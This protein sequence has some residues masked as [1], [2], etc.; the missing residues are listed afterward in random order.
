MTHWLGNKLPEILENR[1]I[2]TRCRCKL[3]PVAGAYACSSCGQSFGVEGGIPVFWDHAD[4][5]KKSEAEFYGQEAKNP[6]LASLIRNYYHS[7]RYDD[8]LTELQFKFLKPN[9]LI[10]SLG[11]G[12][13]SNSVIYVKRGFKVLESDLAPEMAKAA[14]IKFT[15]LGSGEWAVAAIDAEAIPFDEETFDVVFICAALHQM[16]GREKV[17]LEIGRCLKT[18]GFLVLSMEPAAWFYKVIRPLAGLLQIR[19]GQL[20]QQSVGDEANRGVSYRDILG[21]CE[22]AGIKPRVVKPKYFLTGLLYHATEAVYRLLNAK[23]R[24]RLTVRKWELN[25]C[26]TLDSIITHIP[27][28]N[29]YPFYWVVVAEKK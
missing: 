28:I 17:A 18:G 6:S 25:L 29:K 15:T 5:F 3:A 13:G 7:S 8:K 12:D 26:T 21:F 14:S 11:G 16:Q 9:G 1:L 19:S 27:L 24:Q 22:T 2:C 20:G 4:N 10:L 23:T